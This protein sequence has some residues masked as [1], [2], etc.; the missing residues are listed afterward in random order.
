MAR[1]CQPRRFFRPA[2]SP[3]GETLQERD[4]MSQFTYIHAGTTHTDTSRAYMEQ[5]GMSSEQIESVLSQ[6]QFEA[7]K[8]AKLRQEAY[9]NESDPLFMEWQYDQTPEAEQA[10]RNKVSEI[11]ARF[12]F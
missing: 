3:A 8:V 12:A 7:A 9:R 10:W 11:K 2:Q 4:P 6:Y 5:Q 1:S